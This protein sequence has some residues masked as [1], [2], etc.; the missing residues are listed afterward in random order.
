MQNWSCMHPCGHSNIKFCGHVTL[1][2]RIHFS[3]QP[4]VSRRCSFTDLCTHPSPFRH[5]ENFHSIHPSCV[6]TFFQKSL[7]F[8]R[9]IFPKKN[10]SYFFSKASWLFSHFFLFCLFFLCG[11]SLP[12]HL[13]F[14]KY[15]I[16][17]Y[18]RYFCYLNHM[19]GYS[20]YFCYLNYIHV[21]SRYFCYLKLHFCEVF[22]LPKL[23]I[24]VFKLF[25]L[26][27]SHTN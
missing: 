12:K 18:S 7:C 14:V 16:H 26:P 21:Y 1:R 25:L 5:S 24:C 9:W 17:A 11:I 3:Y 20:K 22:L 15:Y 27:K 13:Y 4:N 8:D 23:H 6:H 2:L 10:W 19:H